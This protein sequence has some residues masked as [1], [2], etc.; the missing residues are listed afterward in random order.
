[1]TRTTTIRIHLDLEVESN[2]AE[3]SL[4]SALE[5][6]ISSA[7]QSG[8]LELDSLGAVSVWD[9]HVGVADKG[10]EVEITHWAGGSVGE[11]EGTA[12]SFIGFLGD[13]RKQSGQVFQ[14]ISL[15]NPDVVED[16]PADL[17]LEVITEVNS[18]HRDDREL[19]CVHV[20]A[21][22]GAMEV[23]IFRGPEGLILRLDSDVE[24]V[25][26]VLPCGS[27]AWHLR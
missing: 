13:Q 6:N 27:R 17:S 4:V 3:E 20:G 22:D 15:K 1:M 23:S 26:A 25:R 8:L 7:A 18:L 16:K 14:R 5:R 2:A 12:T 19:P 21:C 9:S 24:L 11:A 10:S